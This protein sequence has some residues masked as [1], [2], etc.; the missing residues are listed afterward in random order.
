MASITER[1]GKFQLRV[2]NRLLPKPFFFT[3]D[4]YERAQTYGQQL[5]A[6]LDRGIVPQDLLEPAEP[7][8]KADPRLSVVIGEYLNLAPV[9]ETDVPLLQLIRGEVGEAR[10]SDVTVRWAE[11]YVRKL[12]AEKNLAPGS[13][14]KRVGSLGRVVD[15]HINRTTEKNETRP[16]NALRLLP[17]GYS[18]YNQQDAENLPDG[19]RPKVDVSRGFR[20]GE[21]IE[22]A[23]KRVLAGEKR[24]D[25][26][27]P[28]PTDPGFPVLFDLI[29]NTGMRLIECFRLRVDQLD[30]QGRLIH[31]E[32]SKGHRGKLKP[33]TVPISTKMAD[34]LRAWCEG[35]KG[36]VFDYWDGSPDD[37]RRC[38]ARLSARFSTLFDY[39]GVPH[40]TEHDLRHEAACRWFLMRLPG[41]GWTFS[42]IEVCKI[43]GWEDTRMALRYASLRGSDL[44]ARM[45]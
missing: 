41:G 25:R 32:G 8:R 39:A 21:E 37:K 30:L 23:V 6:L 45:D 38:S 5:E 4:T 36:L 43:M 7:G 1:A 29:I 28:W 3:F 14:R 42:E 34:Q 20:L 10:V 44:S 15:W 11:D 27:R 18:A 19:M 33:R 24:A 2:K 26:E 40:L 35:R 12:K 17:R 16:P 9:A 13:I 31:V 22:A